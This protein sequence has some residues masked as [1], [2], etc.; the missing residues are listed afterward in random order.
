MNLRGT[1]GEVLQVLKDKAKVLGGFGRMD[2]GNELG[3]SRADGTD[4]LKFGL[5]SNGATSEAEDVASDRPTRAKIS[6]MRSVN[7]ANESIERGERKRA[8][9]LRESRGW[10]QSDSRE[11]GTRSGTPID[12]T[13][14]ASAAKVFADTLEGHIVVFRGGSRK[15]R[16]ERGSIANVGAADDVSIRKFTKD[17][18]KGVANLSLKGAMSRS[19]FSRAKG[20][21]NKLMCQVNRER[22]SVMTISFLGARGF[23]S[24]CL[25]DAINISLTIDH[26]I[27]AGLMYIE[28]IVLDV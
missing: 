8:E 20:K 21:L 15:T 17:L 3:F 9:V 22:N 28:A 26:K 6:S 4:A 10:F 16:Q 18:T 11:E 1:G 12:D 5:I 27:I 7:V 19:A 24:M 25:E 13:P 23:P 2:S 14:V